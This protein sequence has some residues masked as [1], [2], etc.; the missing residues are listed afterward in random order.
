MQK[1]GHNVNSYTKVNNIIHQAELS[2]SMM[3]FKMHTYQKEIVTK[4]KYWNSESG[5]KVDIFVVT[6]DEFTWYGY[7]QVNFSWDVFS[8]MWYKT[9]AVFIS[10]YTFIINF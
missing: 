5:I 7:R 3:I 10:N 4:C 6:K 9:H 8:A 2:F 1:K